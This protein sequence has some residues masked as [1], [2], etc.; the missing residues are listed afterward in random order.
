MRSLWITLIVLGALLS[1]MPAPW[2]A[3][4]AIPGIYALPDHRPK[5]TGELR[6][7]PTTGNAVAL[8]FV[9]RKTGTTTPLRKYD[10]E[11][12]KQLH[13]IAVSDDFASFLHEHVDHVA[14][15]GHFRLTMSFPHPGRYHVYAD[16]TPSGIGQQV[17]RFDLP[18]ASTEAPR[19]PAPPEPSGLEGTDGTYTVKF[20]NL[21]LEAGK[22]TMLELHILKGDQPARDVKPFLGVAA[23]AVF[24]NTTDLLYVHVHATPLAGKT[25]GMGDMGAMAGR[26]HMQMAPTK[27]LRSSSVIN[28]N[29]SLHVAPPE[30]GIYKLWIQ[31]TGGTQ[32]RTVP[33]VVSVK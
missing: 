29:L 7:T 31:F 19:S 32:V 21:S 12:T 2:A 20:D 5:V 9:M 23:H 8:D 17:L 33:F 10:I 14:K 28:P 13:V 11:L 25:S 27:A 3:S 4:E 15:D 22:E 16:G 6:A 24:I 30:S 26:E 1:S 18:V